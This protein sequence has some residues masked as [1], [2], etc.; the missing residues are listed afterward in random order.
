MEGRKLKH[1]RVHVQPSYLAP[2]GVE[3]P[4]K[5]LVDH[6]A[7]GV[8]GIHE[9]MIG[10]LTFYALGCRLGWHGEHGWSLCGLPQETSIHYGVLNQSGT[11]IPVEFRRISGGAR[12]QVSR[13]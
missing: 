5:S 10:Y 6:S 1:A 7:F 2:S 4:C 8:L 3:D 11:R 13:V 12:S 9:F